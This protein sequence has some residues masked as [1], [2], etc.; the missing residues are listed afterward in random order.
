[1]E[2]F[3]KLHQRDA[4]MS[5]L[6]PKLLDGVQITKAD[7]HK[8]FVVNADKSAGRLMTREELCALPISEIG[9]WYEIG[10]FDVTV[11]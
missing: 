7:L 10:E 1:M 11:W 4:L 3:E 2:P 9:E 6:K 8:F 5:R